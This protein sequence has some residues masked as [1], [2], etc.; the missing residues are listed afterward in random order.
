MVLRKPCPHGNPT[1]SGCKRCK[2]ENVSR[3]I[4]RT[5]EN[6]PLKYRFISIMYNMRRR[7]GAPVKVKDLVELWHQQQGLCHYCDTPMSYTGGARHATTVSVDRI[8]SNLPYVKENIVLACWA[9]NA[10]KGTF[11]ADEYVQH[12]KLVANKFPDA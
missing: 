8:N 4:N 11:S 5:K 3:S 1:T 2:V 12:C 10:G 6:D 7:K 9:C